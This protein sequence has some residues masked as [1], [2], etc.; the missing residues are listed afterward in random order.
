[1]EEDRIEQWIFS[2]WETSKESKKLFDLG[3]RKLIK[4]AER[5][6]YTRKEEQHG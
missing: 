5:D 4:E 3:I 1:M 2:L 6:N